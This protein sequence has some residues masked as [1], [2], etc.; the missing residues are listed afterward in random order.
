MSSL[1]FRRNTIVDSVFQELK[2]RII[3]G[4]YEAG[5]QLRQDSLASEMGVSRI[6][7]REALLRLEAEGLIEI[8]AHKGGIVRSLSVKE[9]DE[10]F[11]LRILIE[12]NLMRQALP[13]M[14]EDDFDQAVV[15]LKKFDKMVISGEN[16]DQWTK[17]NWDFHCEFYKPAQQPYT[18]K[19]LQMLHSNTDRYIRQ[20]LLNEGAPERAHDEHNRL[21]ELG[22]QGKIDEAC[23][24]LKNHITATY[25]QVKPSLS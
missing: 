9:A 16:I 10:L 22:R 13:N 23:D 18:I 14:S 6:P 4:E 25:E 17:L 7:I 3:S 5:F 20:Q 8:I 24:L 1:P 15:A 12:C 11:N 2:K 19:I 21:I